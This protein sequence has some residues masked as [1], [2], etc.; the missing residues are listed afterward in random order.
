MLERPHTRDAKTASHMLP[1]DNTCRTLSIW[2][3]SYTWGCRGRGCTQPSHP[4]APCSRCRESRQQCQSCRSCKI[5]AES[6]GPTLLPDTRESCRS[7]HGGEGRLNSLRATFMPPCATLVRR[8]G[9]TSNRN[10]RTFSKASS[11]F[12]SR[13]TLAATCVTQ[14]ALSQWTGGTKLD[15]T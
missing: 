2:A 4:S 6:A 10:R 7:V 11:A 9:P 1:N 5:F 14:R 15:R 13:W 12:T 3:A 8:V